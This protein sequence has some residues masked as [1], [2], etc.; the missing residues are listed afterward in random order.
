MM[1]RSLRPAR[2]TG[3]TGV[4]DAPPVGILRL[5]K[6]VVTDE[7]VRLEER[8]MLTSKGRLEVA[9]PRYLTPMY[10]KT[11]GPLIAVA[12]LLANPLRGWTPNAPEAMALYED[13]EQKR[14]NTEIK[15]LM[16]L[17]T[18]SASLEKKPPAKKKPKKPS[19]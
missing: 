3:D 1:L 7:R 10:Q 17:A 12:T 8:E 5:S 16:D 13:D 18:P 19:K 9:K 6:Y 2:A 14:R 15:D 4:S 11:L